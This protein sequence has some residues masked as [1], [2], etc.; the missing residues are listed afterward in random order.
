MV[1][2][3]ENSNRRTIYP[4]PVQIRRGDAPKKL[5]STRNSFST[6]WNF[7]IECGLEEVFLHTSL[8][9]FGEDVFRYGTYDS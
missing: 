3:G 4:F 6:L 5:S 8:T 2:A 9:S 1:S 7:L